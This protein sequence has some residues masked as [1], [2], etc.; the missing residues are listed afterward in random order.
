[1]FKPLPHERA[2]EAIVRQLKE[3]IY[4]NR[5]KPGEKLPT[6]R[7]L[8]KMFNASSAA[9]RS[10]VLNLEQ[11]GLLKIKKGAGGGFFV[12]DLD[13]KPFR[14][15]LN[16]LVSFGK[17]S[18]SHLA[19]ARGALEPEASRLASQ[20]ATPDDVRKIEKSIRDLKERIK[21]GL[22]RHT[23]DFDFHVWVAEASKNPI[24]IVFTRSLMDLL[25]RNI[26]SRVLNEQENELIIQEHNKILDAIKKRDP[27]KSQALA[28]EHSITM[29]G[30]FER[31]ENEA[32][33]HFNL[34]DGGEP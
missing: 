24:I 9:V 13:F 10:A 32:N 29:R 12:Q 11:A 5:L 18:V 26:G 33:F 22:P 23:D 2:F 19:E 8:A 3:A 31:L 4:S 25:F 15:S 20:R 17:A 27:D 28:L 34:D 30:L 1:M 14:D 7:G 21:H 16:D 6:E